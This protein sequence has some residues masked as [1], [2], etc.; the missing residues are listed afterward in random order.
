MNI[1]ISSACF[2][3]DIPEKAVDFLVENKIGYA[4]FFLNCY[5]EFSIDFIKKLKK[6][7][8][9]VPTEIFALHPFSSGFENRLFF[10]E[11]RRL[12]SDG[13]EIYKRFFEAAAYMNADLFIL[14]G[15]DR[16]S[17]I[18][19]NEYFERFQEI[20]RAAASFGI[21]LAQENVANFKSRSVDFIKNMKNQLGDVVFTLDI[22][23]CRRASQNVF[24]MAKAMGNSLR[25]IHL[26]D[27]DASHDCLPP[28]T[29]SFDFGKFF[30]LID[31]ICDKT[32][33]AVIELYKKNYSSPSQL[34]SS[35]NYLRSCSL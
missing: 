25:H 18:S 21:R 12:F 24:D 23:Q 16:Y 29:G 14:H 32:P 27:S 7:L 2:F 6:N 4:E 31:S 5:S 33:S 19:D 30:E 3:P 9:T 35:L 34:V 28:G 13:L 20:D 22:K 11:Y 8:D 17:S 26:S 1:G 15:A 10:S